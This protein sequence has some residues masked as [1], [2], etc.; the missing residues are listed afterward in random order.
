MEENFDQPVLSRPKPHS[1]LTSSETVKIIE[2]FGAD[3]LFCFWLCYQ[4]LAIQTQKGKKDYK[5]V[6]TF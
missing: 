6:S 5:S 2:L 3:C 4:I 1:P